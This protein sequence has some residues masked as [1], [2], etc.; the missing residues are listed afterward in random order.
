MTGGLESLTKEERRALRGSK[1][2]PLPSA[3]PPSQSRPRLSH[4]GGPLAT[5]KAAALAKFLERKLQKPGGLDSI[6]P[7]LL[8]LA[9]KNAKDTVN[10]AVPNSG[11]IRHVTSFDDSKDSSE[12]D[13]EKQGKLIESKV[14]IHKKKR[15]RGR[16]QKDS[17]EEDGENQD[18]GEGSKRK[19]CKKNRKKN[20]GQKM[21][22]SSGK[23]RIQKKGEPMSP[24]R[25]FPLNG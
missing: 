14:M 18:K 12:E 6:N 3:P 4:P 9:V 16:K 19:K 11:R 5:N 13:V 21:V 20:E 22:K 10:G 25:K 15:K 17:R 1:F 8:E 2:A 7:D 24:A 23:N